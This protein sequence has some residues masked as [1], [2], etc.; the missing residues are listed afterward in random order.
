M[1]VLA[2]NLNVVRT[3]VKGGIPCNR[4]SYLVIIIH[5]NGSLNRN[6]SVLLK[7][8]KP[9]HLIRCFSHSTTIGIN[10]IDCIKACAHN[11]D[12]LPLKMSILAD[13]FQL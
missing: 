2:I 6:T 9:Y 3:L 10:N 4:D 13:I 12:Q 11:M 1:N 8:S 7:V 5:M